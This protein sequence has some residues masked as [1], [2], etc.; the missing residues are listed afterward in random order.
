MADCTGTV[1]GTGGWTGP[2]PGDPDNNS[3]LSA[4]PAFGG[5]DVSWTY[6]TINPY[7]VA[8]TILY[9]G[10]LDNFS[11]AVRRAVVDGSTFFDRLDDEGGIEYFYW[12]QLVSVNGTYGDPIGPASAVPRGTIDETIVQL[13]GKI[14]SGVLATSLRQDIDRITTIGQDLIAEVNNRIA[15]NDLFGASLQQVQSEMS[16]AMTYVNDEII[17]RTEADNALLQ[18]INTLVGAVGANEAAIQSIQSLEVYDDSALVSDIETLYTKTGDLESAVSIEST[19][20]SDADNALAEQITTAQ[21]TLGSNIA[22]VQTTLESNIDTVNGRVTDI[23]ALYTAKLSV[24]GLIGGFGVYNDG[25]EVEAG[26]DVDSFWVGRTGTDLKK[27]FIIQ[28]SEVFIDKAVIQTLTADDIDTRGLTIKDTDGNVILSSGVPLN[29]S[30]LQGSPTSA[31]LLNANQQWSDVTGIPYDTI[32]SNDDSVALGFNPTFSKWTSVAPA[33]WSNWNGTPAKETTIKRI[34]D[35]SVKYSPDGINNFGML[36]TA[37]WDAAPLPEGTFVSGTVDI[38]LG[39]WAGPGRPGIRVDLYTAAGGTNAHPTRV[40]ITETTTGV[41][42]R[43]PFTARVPTGSRIYGMRIYVFGCYGSGDSTWYGGY[44]SGTVYFDNLRFAFFDSSV[45][46]KTVSIGSNGSLSGAGGG[47][48]TIT[49]LGYSGALNATYGADVGST[50]RRAGVPVAEADLVASWN[51]ISSSNAASFFNSAGLPGTYIQNLQASKILAGALGVSQW[52][53]SVGYIPGAAGWAINADGS[54][55]FRD[56]VVR[57]D[58]EATTIKAGS[59]NII[60]TLMVQGEAITFPRSIYTAGTTYVGTVF[61]DV[62]SYTMDPAGGSVSIVGKVSLAITAPSGVVSM[63]TRLLDPDNVVLDESVID[64]GNASSI[65]GFSC[66]LGRATKSGT[67]RMQCK[68]GVGAGATGTAS[69]RAML[70]IGGKR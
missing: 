47:Q 37:L 52:I 11:L 2:K 26:F 42:Q 33:G 18:Q 41:W 22:S 65:Q 6:P 4:T 1:C 70:L 34:G 20:R 61:T 44:W 48:V 58:V 31:D 51:K 3:I 36:R 68:L 15:A 64:N 28:G 38:Y 32:Y 54:A 63:T 43:V 12:I 55:E 14:D 53:S 8:H 13:T 7:A 5:I 10:L 40:P 45:D 69:N 23:G 9:R 50:L 49:G 66:V 21:T 60:D 62:Q 59:L 35:F 57:G 56:I 29:F 30:Y 67:Y 19:A 27:P 46:N 24:N 16:S 17:Q 39:S 25:T